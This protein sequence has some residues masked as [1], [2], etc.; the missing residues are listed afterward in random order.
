[1]ATS[2]FI[3]HI[4]SAGERWDLLAWRFYGDPTE[5]SPIIMANPSVSIEAVF[6]AGITI[7]IPILNPTSTPANLPPWKTSANGAA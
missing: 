1:M 7:Y 5:Y 6:E 4:T 2:Q 3:A